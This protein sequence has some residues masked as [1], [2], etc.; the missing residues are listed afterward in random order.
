MIGRFH[1][2]YT[3]AYVSLV[4]DDT[5]GIVDRVLTGKIEAGVV[6]ARIAQDY[7]QYTPLMKD[8]MILVTPMNHPWAETGVLEKTENLCRAAFIMR[9]QGSGTRTAML[10]ALSA[11]GVTSSDLNVVAELGSTEAVRQAVKAGL[12]VSILSRRAVEDD[13][14]FN[15]IKHIKAPGL[16]LKRTFLLVTHGSRT[17]SPLGEAFIEFLKEKN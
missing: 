13:L 5:Q 1:A 10:E 16:N 2:K 7:L 15:L 12:G 8:E 3:D 14:R 6:G 4:I 11:Q 9:E 17:R